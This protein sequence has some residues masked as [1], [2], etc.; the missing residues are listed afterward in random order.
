MTDMFSDS[1]Y[2]HWRWLY[3]NWIL[4]EI[5]IKESTHDFYY[6]NAVKNIVRK[7]VAILFIM[8]KNPV[9]FFTPIFSLFQVSRAGHR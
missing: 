1:H 9:Y 8:Q 5:L 3:A 6:D 4:N 7:M 2:Q